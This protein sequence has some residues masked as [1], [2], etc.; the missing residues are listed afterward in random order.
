VRLRYTVPALAD[1]ESVLD[2]IAR[3]SPQGT[4]RVQ[5]RIQTVIDVLLQPPHIGTRTGNP[6]IR[7]MTALPYPYLIFDEVT[8]K[9]II[10]HAV[11]HA[12]RNP[13][14]M[15]GTGY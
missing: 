14:D 10:I 4:R 5:S 9:E 13:S 1:L 6:T 11:R 7:R 3:H 15:P 8:G 2:Y 12:A